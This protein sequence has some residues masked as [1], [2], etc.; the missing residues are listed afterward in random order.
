LARDSQRK[1]SQLKKNVLLQCFWSLLNH[2]WLFIQITG[3]SSSS[4]FS[5]QD[6]KQPC[7]SLEETLNF[8]LDLHTAGLRH[9]H[10]SQHSYHPRNSSPNFENSMDFSRP[11]FRSSFTILPRTT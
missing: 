9:L 2:S 3:H 6:G 11:K 10:C 7:L 4:L 1:L 8:P 5:T